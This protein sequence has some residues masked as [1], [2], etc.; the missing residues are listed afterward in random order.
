MLQETY[1]NF[2]TCLFTVA[3]T[4][5]PLDDNEELLYIGYNI[6]YSI[7]VGEGGLFSTYSHISSTGTLFITNCRLIYIPKT[8]TTNF[9]SFFCKTNG[10]IN[11]TVKSNNKIRLEI[12]LFGNVI[13][14]LDLKMRDNLSATLLEVLKLSQDYLNSIQ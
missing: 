5:L 3:G 6:G 14:K 9:C 8:P 1:R 12:S 7:T 10:I 4:P 11:T 2:N 13:S